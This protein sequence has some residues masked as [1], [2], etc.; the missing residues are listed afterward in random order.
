MNV[1]ELLNQH[2]SRRLVD[3]IVELIGYDK[4]LFDEVV[5]LSF[6]EPYPINM[7]ASWVIQHYCAKNATFIQ[8]H[9]D[10]ILQKLNSSQV[11]GVKRNYIKIFACYANLNKIENLGKLIDLC[12]LFFNDPAET[13]AVRVFCLD[14]LLKVGETEPDLIPE[15]IDSIM[16]HSEYFSAG[17][18]N[19]AGKVIK[20]LSKNRI[21]I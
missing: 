17:L 18:K 21:S 19:K 5:A 14:V 3:S 16:F 4:E 11:A 12:F 7:R 8:S 9:L 15:I 1:L 10:D 6:S 2:S 20:K 13:I